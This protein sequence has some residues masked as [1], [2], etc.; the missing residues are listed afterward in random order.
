MQKSDNQRNDNGSAAQPTD[1]V[2]K[3][4]PYGGRRPDNLNQSK[5]Q[6]HE[7]PKDCAFPPLVSFVV[8]RD[9]LDGDQRG[10]AGNSDNHFRRPNAPSLDRLG[11]PPPYQ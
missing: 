5:K 11:A 3:Q 2:S 4:K 10:R 8:H 1:T 7:Q 9:L 6:P